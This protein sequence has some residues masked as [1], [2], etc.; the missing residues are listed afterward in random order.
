MAQPIPST[1][2]TR[3]PGAIGAAVAVVLGCAALTEIHCSIVR[4]FETGSSASN[5]RSF[6]VTGASIDSGGPSVRTTT[7]IAKD[8]R[9]A[10]EK[11]IAGRIG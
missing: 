8:S 4:T 2:G 5:S 1:T 7:S 11:Y 3:P 9:A 10:A 6:D